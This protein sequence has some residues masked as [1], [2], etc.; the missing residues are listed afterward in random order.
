MP[1]NDALLEEIRDLLV[2]L[3]A[4]AKGQLAVHGPERLKSLVGSGQRQRA[5]KMMDG[6]KT[7][8]DIQK[9]TG[10]SA[11]NLSTLVKELREAGL[12]TERDSKPRL[13]IAP[14]S[15]WKGA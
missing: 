6:S 11:P 4:I 15:V 2:P 7:R 3:S 10:I 1:D 14:V 8:S 12:V 13:I 9:A 5:A